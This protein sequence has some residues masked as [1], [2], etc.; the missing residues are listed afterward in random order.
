[1]TNPHMYSVCLVH[2]L[3]FSMT[4]DSIVVTCMAGVVDTILTGSEVVWISNCEAMEVMNFGGNVTR[5]L[6]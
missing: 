3:P 5:F 4:G 6:N 2:V 1:M